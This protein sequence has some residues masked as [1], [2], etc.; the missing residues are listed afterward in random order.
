MTQF[1]LLV[2]YYQQLPLCLLLIFSSFFDLKPFTSCQVAGSTHGEQDFSQRQGQ[3]ACQAAEGP[4]NASTKTE[5]CQQCTPEAT[6]AAWQ[7]EDQN[8]HM[9]SC[10]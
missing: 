9:V 3:T 2:L 7:A 1:D 5:K 10:P 8:R 4:L 6:S